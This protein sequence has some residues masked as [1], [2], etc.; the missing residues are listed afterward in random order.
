LAA[1]AGDVADADV[2]EVA[3]CLAAPVDEGL[4]APPVLGEL[5]SSGSWS[6]GGGMPGA[7]VNLGDG[8]S[9]G[10]TARPTAARPVADAPPPEAASSSTGLA[11]VPAAP[12]FACVSVMN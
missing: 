3:P 10:T 7:R 11:E 6:G 5:E 4:S 2:V 12:D 8:V 9:G 1:S